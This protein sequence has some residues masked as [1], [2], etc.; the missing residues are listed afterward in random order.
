LEEAL[1]NDGKGSFGCMAVTAPVFLSENDAIELIQVE[2]E[3][4]GL[5]LKTGV[6]V[7]GL[8]IP[9]TSP[10]IRSAKTK[11]SED[12]MQKLVRSKDDNERSLLSTEWKKTFIADLVEGSYTF[13]LGTE[14]KSVVVKFLNVK[15]HQQWREDLD[16]WRLSVESW[17]LAW[18]ATHVRDAFAARNEGEP[19]VIGLF[20][21][22]MTYPDEKY[23]FDHRKYDSEDLEQWE[24]Y[25]KQ[26]WEI[27]RVQGDKEAKEI[28]TEK[29]RQQ[30]LYFVEYLKKEGVIEK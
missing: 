19:V 29:L 3:K 27:D 17:D 12:I 4:V 14:D 1:A 10:E 23:R 21:D 9:T 11:K 22:P 15:E 20:F 8:H 24:K 28:A 18:L 6:T 13:D 25:R 30:V 7:D 16:E 5:N 26:W 2:L